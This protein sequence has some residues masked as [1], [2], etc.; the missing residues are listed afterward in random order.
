LDELQRRSATGDETH[1]EQRD[2]A[3]DYVSSETQV[4]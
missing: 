2:L 4:F 1:I 3:D